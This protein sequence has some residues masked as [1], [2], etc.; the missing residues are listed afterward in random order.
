MSRFRL[1]AAAAAVSLLVSLVPAAAAHA[2]TTTAEPQV[3]VTLMAANG[4]GC[5][6]GSAYAVPV[7]DGTAFTLTY[8]EF[9]ATGSSFKN[10]LA[11][12][13]VDVPSGW[14]YAIYQVIN[15][16]FALLD[17]GASGRMQM[18][19][20]FTNFPWTLTETKVIDGPYNDFWQTINAAGALT[21]APCGGA[22]YNLNVN[23]T[24]SVKGT[25]ASSM[26][27]F[28][29]DIGAS[30]IFRLQFRQCP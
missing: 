27:F 11:I 15:R 9:M 22:A 20:W 26:A 19:S 1:A 25:D 24:V 16:G 5:P 3:K 2:A 13:R 18:N 29:T 17:S 12:V 10:C 23:N 28:A 6:F 21:W 4:S 8:S 7:E 30:T 14:T